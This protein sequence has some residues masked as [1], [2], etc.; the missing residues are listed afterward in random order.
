MKTLNE[1]TQSDPSLA[2]DAL[3]G[4]EQP[5]NVEVEYYAT[6]DEDF[7]YESP[8]EAAQAIWDDGDCEVGDTVTVYALTFQKAQ[9][10]DF[11]P[12]ISEELQERA[13]SEIGERALDWNFTREESEALQRAVAATVDKWCADNKCRSGLWWPVGTSTKLR[14]RLTSESGDVESLPNK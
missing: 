14:Y 3:F 12:F 7:N 6:N 8:E 5:S 1:P 10:S 9:E 11:L 4:S 2:S 13:Y